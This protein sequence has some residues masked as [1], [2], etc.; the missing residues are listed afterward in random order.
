VQL[1]H[2]IK[3]V[4]ASLTLEITSLAKRLKREGVDIVD[5][6]SGEPDFDTPLQIKAEAIRAIEEGF[7]KYTPTSGILELKEKIKAKFK[8]DN[9][10]EYETEQIV[11][12]CGAKHS[13]YNTIQV[14]LEK[15][16]QAIIPCPFWVSYPEMVK[17]SEAEPIILETQPEDKFKVIPKKLEK[18]ITPRTKL[19]ILNSPNNPVGYIYTK[20]ELEEIASICVSKNIYVLSDEVYEKII[21]DENRHFSIASLNKDIYDL[22]IT[23]N[24]V[25]KSFSMTGWRIGYLGAPKEIAKAIE[26]LQDHSTSNPTSI[27]QKAALAALNMG[28]DF[29]KEMV[30]EFQRRRDYITDILDSLQLFYVKPQGAFYIFCDIS[31]TNLDSINFSK[32]LLEERKVLVTPGAGFGCEGFIRISFATK[33][34]DIKRGMERFS[35]WVRQLLKR[36]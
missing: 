7:T 26:R 6:A 3:N 17:L 12:S 34:E 1:A 21:F 8:N 13:L 14:L 20:E 16:E 10:L 36:S 19:L 28:E 11:V 18:T 25:S 22:T 5:F 2:R 23:I 29:Y 30:K 24:G 27:S 4:S 35:E 32:R 15:G 31:K 33:I 9:N